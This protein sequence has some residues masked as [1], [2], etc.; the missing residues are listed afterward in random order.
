M[1][2]IRDTPM[3][4]AADMIISIIELSFFLVINR[5][6]KYTAAVNLKMKF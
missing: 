6:I 3:P 2:A 4:S 5:Y 1:S